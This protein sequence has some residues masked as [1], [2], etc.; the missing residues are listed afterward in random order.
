MQFFMYNTKAG[1]ERRQAAEEELSTLSTNV[2]A[3]AQNVSDG[4]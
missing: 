2:M 3:W 1:R 4:L